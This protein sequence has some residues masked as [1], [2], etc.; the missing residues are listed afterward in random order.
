MI[1]TDVPIVVNVFSRFCYVRTPR[2]SPR[3]N[4]F[5]HQYVCKQSKRHPMHFISDGYEWTPFN[6]HIL[7]RRSIAKH[8]IFLFSPPRC[9]HGGGGSPRRQRDV[10][11]TDTM[12]MLHFQTQFK[13]ALLCA[14]TTLCSFFHY[15]KMNGNTR[16]TQMKPRLPVMKTII[17]VSYIHS[18]PTLLMLVMFSAVTCNPRQL[19][20]CGGAHYPHC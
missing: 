16:F 3:K 1:V 4:T 2:A 19:V 20:S 10:G 15:H 8:V 9:R 12:I 11:Q 17:L 5:L 6:L 13:L 7:K 14:F 18:R